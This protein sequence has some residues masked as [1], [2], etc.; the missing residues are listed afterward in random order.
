MR[1]KSLLQSNREYEYFFADGPI[2]IDIPDDPPR[3]RVARP[4]ETMGSVL[5]TH[6][7]RRTTT[8]MRMAVAR[9]VERNGTTSTHPNVAVVGCGVDDPKMVD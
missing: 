2:P 3:M 9:H 7:T 8:M 6:W 1:N 5:G 4:Y